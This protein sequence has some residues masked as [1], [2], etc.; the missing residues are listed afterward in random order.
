[1]NRPY[2][3]GS[4]VSLA[5]L[6]LWHL[7]HLAAGRASAQAP[8][9]AGGP[10]SGVDHRIFTSKAKFRLPVKIDARERARLQE[11]QLW[12]K[13]PP[14][15][16]ER[17][18]TAPPSQTD[19]EYAVA[20][21][22]EYWF[23]VVTVDR[24]GR[25]NPPD[26]RRDAPGLMVVVDTQP[27][28]VELS[29]A[30][31]PA[32][33]AC[34]RCTVKDRNPDY[35]TLKVCYQGPDHTWHALDLLP[36]QPDLF[37]LPRSEI[38][39]CTLRATVQDRAHNP[40][41]CEVSLA[42]LQRRS[43]R[44]T[45]QTAAAKAAADPG[46]VPAPPSAGAAVPPPPRDFP[47]AASAPV[48]APESGPAPPIRDSH[49]ERV[50]MKAGADAE[51][52]PAERQLLGCTRATVEYRLDQVGPS[53]VSKVEIYITS[54]RGRTW[55][56]LCEDPDR[57][58]PAQIDLPGDGLFGIR[59]AVT[60]GNG[61]GGTPPAP[62]DAPTSWIEVDT[63]P[64]RAQLHDVDPVATGGALEVRWT[65]TDKNL[66]PEPI[67]LSYSTRKEGPW[68]PIARG[69]KNDGVYRWTFPRDA[70]SQFFVRLEATDLVGN[71]T[72]CELPSPVVLDMT[73]PRALVTSISGV[74]PRPTPP[75]GN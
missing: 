68:M 36:G 1:M 65:V 44:A 25:P 15:D 60:N 57:R 18:K 53:G 6:V 59:L 54:D 30:R 23:S 12:V 11:I 52:A 41:S 40:T 9:A 16:W 39:D 45:A 51:G 32:G 27:P 70:G 10:A 47:N 43:G 66:G 50:A 20:Q 2:R 31:G 4:W 67:S 19:F 63:T 49:I 71:S 75:A 21:D 48:P 56:R 73:E 24:D 64:P 42:E 34:L 61:F 46:P 35:Q 74:T 8:T 26:V 28:A 7:T 3:L 14:G 62:G 33:E 58:S 22:G 55:R 17:K 72:K 69:L 38:R 5:V 29:A 37:R 13:A